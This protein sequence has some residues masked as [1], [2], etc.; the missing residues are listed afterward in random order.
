MNA[1]ESAIAGV[2]VDTLRAVAGSDQSIIA[3]PVGIGL[4]GAA[5]ALLMAVQFWFTRT[6]ATLAFSLR[7]RVS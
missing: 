5:W 2:V 4:V 3:G 1:V 7:E 6:A